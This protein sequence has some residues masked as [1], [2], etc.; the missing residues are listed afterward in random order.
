M[1]RINKTTQQ[2]TDY[3][4]DALG[5]DGA[6]MLEA[7]QA[8]L[9]MRK[10]QQGESIATFKQRGAKSKIGVAR[11]ETESP[12][13]E[14]SPALQKAEAITGD[15]PLME[16]F[17]IECTRRNHYYRGEQGELILSEDTV[18]YPDGSQE[19]RIEIELGGGGE[20]LLR[21]AHRKMSR[22][23]PGLKEAKT[24]KQ[25]EARKRMVRLLG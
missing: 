6:P 10:H 21:E 4:Y 1:P 2:Y 13:G 24:G 14:N 20:R 11:K 12:A 9:R 18:T 23:N 19:E 15:K 22:R 25:R 3:Y 16:L 5:A 17:K 8:S 7:K